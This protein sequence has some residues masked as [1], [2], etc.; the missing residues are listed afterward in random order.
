MLEREPRIQCKAIGSQFLDCFL[1]M[2]GKTVASKLPISE[3]QG[4][5]G[6]TAACIYDQDGCGASDQAI[7]TP[8]LSSMDPVEDIVEYPPNDRSSEL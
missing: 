1:A 4:V 7:Q 3:P 8:A 6:K 5:H 2:I